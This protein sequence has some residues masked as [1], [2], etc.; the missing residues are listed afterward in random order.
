MHVFVGF[1][2]RE[3]DGFAVT[4]HSILKHNPNAEIH[5]LV[6]DDLRQRGLYTRPTNIVNGKLYDEISQAPMATE[7]AISRFLVP[8]LAKQLKLSGWVWFMDCDMLVRNQLPD[9]FDNSKALY[10][11]K[12]DHTQ[13]DTVKMDGCKQIY[14]ERKNWSSVMAFNVDH[15]S[16]ETLTVRLVNQLAGRD[17]HAFSWLKDDEIDELDPDWNHLVGVN[18]P[19]PNAGVVHYTLGIPSMPGYDDCEHANEWYDTLLEWAK[20]QP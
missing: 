20:W 11:V 19:N 2:P 13:G 5:G 1:D 16:N 15:P 7:F 17:M 8:H 12:H 14:Y 3:V 18:D 6:L 4:C 10:C 9:N